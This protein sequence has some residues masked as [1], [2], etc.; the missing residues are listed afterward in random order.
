[1]TTKQ[2]R[3]DSWGKI[4]ITPRWSIL[5]APYV[6]LTLEPTREF[7]DIDITYQAKAFLL[8]DDPE[9]FKFLSIHEFM[10]V[11]LALMSEGYTMI[12]TE[13]HVSH[14]LDTVYNVVTFKRN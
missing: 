14:Y 7:P 2:Q 4:S 5:R 10:V 8:Q 13:E 12:S 1:M 3:N 11:I 9:D 6:I